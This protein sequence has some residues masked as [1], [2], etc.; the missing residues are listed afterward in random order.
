MENNLSKPRVYLK[1]PK[2]IYF[3]R[4]NLNLEYLSPMEYFLTNYY[5]FICIL[6]INELKI[7]LKLLLRY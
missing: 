1:N 4:S 5:C 3:K 2:Y 7:F 6:N